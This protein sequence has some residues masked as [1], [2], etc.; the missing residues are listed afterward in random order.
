M[1]TMTLRE[2]APALA[3]ELEGK[4]P[5]EILGAIAP[6]FPRW[7]ALASAFGAEDCV[8]VDVIARAGL[9]IFELQLTK[10]RRWCLGL[11]AYAGPHPCGKQ[12]GR[13]RARGRAR[14]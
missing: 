3:R 7:I 1:T 13:A 14:R 5:A 2:Q 9:P 6:R 10:A 4:P 8:L 12:R 11:S